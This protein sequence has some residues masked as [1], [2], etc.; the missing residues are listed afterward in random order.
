MHGRK[1]ESPYDMAA[2]S[3]EQLRISVVR[4]G[5]FAGIRRPLGTIDTAGLSE[6]EAVRLRELVERSG[7]F[8]LPA[9]LP[10][11]NEELRDQFSYTVS[12]RGSQREHTVHPTEG[13]VVQPLV[14]FVRE[15][16]QRESGNG[17]PSAD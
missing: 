15:L 14:D 12:V 5:G 2:A 17:K 9:V 10:A 7:F 11:A 16:G 13:S 6:Q 1:W 3:E 8:D 4:S